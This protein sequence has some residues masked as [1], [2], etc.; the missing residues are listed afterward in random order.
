MGDEVLEAKIITGSNIG[1][2]GLLGYPEGVTRE[3][4]VQE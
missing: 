3:S 1:K 4:A 2:E